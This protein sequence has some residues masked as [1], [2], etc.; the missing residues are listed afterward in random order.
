[1]EINI[2][3]NVTLFA[4]QQQIELVSA[5]IKSTASLTNS[6]S[7]LNTTDVAVGDPMATVPYQTIISGNKFTIFVLSPSKEAQELSSKS[8]SPSKLQPLLR[9]CIDHPLCTMTTNNESVQ[10]NISCYD[11]HVDLAV[12]DKKNNHSSEF[13]AVSAVV[14]C[15]IISLE[16]H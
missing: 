16:M 3:S 9:L 7:T 5:V 14:Y 8:S 11:A 4:G 12:G 1:V 10:Y 15:N 2:S 6:T 13:S